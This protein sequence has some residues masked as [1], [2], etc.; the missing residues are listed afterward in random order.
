MRI[1]FLYPDVG[2]MLPPDYQHGV[3]ILM[4]LLR[5]AGHEPGLIY[6][7]D[8]I[9][10][11]DLIA[12]V[13]AFNPGLFAVSSASNQYPRAKRYAAWVKE[14]VGL[15]IAIGG[16]HAT[17][18]PEEAMAEPSF[19]LLCRGEAEGAMVELADAMERGAD[20]SGIQNLWVRRG[21]E[22]IK[23]EVRPL[24]EDLDS[25][26]F[27]DRDGF[28]FEWILEQREGNCSI[29]SGRGCPYG[30]T[31]CANE[32]LRTLYRDKGRFVRMRSVAN[33]LAEMR[34]I[35]GRYAVKKWDFNDDIFT[36][37]REWLKQ[38]CEAYP[39]EFQLPFDVNVRV[40]TVDEESLGWL[41]AA[42][43]E[44]IRVGVESGSE[45]V[46]REIMGRRMK[47]EDIERVFA[48]ADRVG[49]RTWS[50]NMTGLPGETPAD[51]EETW[52]LN[53]RLCPDH[54]QVSVFNPYPATRLH[55][56]CAER[57]VFTGETR[58]GYFVP[59]C[60]LTLPEFP[61]DA[62]R[63]AHQKLVRLRDFCHT[64]KKL[65]R[66]LGGPPVF[67]LVGLLAEA[68]V[69]TPE[70]IFVGED[71]FTI[72]ND[73][74][75]VLRV[76][77]P[78]RVRFQL[79]LPDAPGLRFALAMHPQ[80]WDK[81]GGDGVVFTVRAGRF[82]RTMKTVFERALDPKRVTSDRPWHEAAVDLSAWA[83][84][85]IYLELSTR[86]VDPARPDHNTVGFGFPVIVRR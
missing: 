72:D 1:L 66:E 73:T 34:E 31:Y 75:R 42:G 41:K 63:E 18:A 36:L 38:F 57:G 32:G 80:V 85:R 9:G 23:N 30:C 69:E 79:K 86:T 29:L 65:R 76:H 54:M 70:A 77:P 2:T 84:K 10:R 53:R 33:V 21:A 74:R 13:R 8:E 82:V 11:D 71:F 26:P 25:L 40:E 12:R 35:L 37:K 50:F 27:P 51:A 43:C 44:W 78:S 64:T 45:R 7:H 60:S 3:G 14:D 67:D 83:G 55:A 58:D 6:L 46:R 39:R 49:L 5:R 47:T 4:A 17:L 62:V 24:V 52:A 81:P 61:P 68:V 15:P 59:D 56:L 16:I 28:P 19:D 22:V 48:A 20:Y